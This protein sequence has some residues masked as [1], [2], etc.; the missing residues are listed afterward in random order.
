M[1][2]FGLL[3]SLKVFDQS[4]KHDA[5]LDNSNTVNAESSNSNNNTEI[6]D[7]KI[8]LS[9]PS[10][11]HDDDENIKNSPNPNSFDTPAENP[12]IQYPIDSM[13]TNYIK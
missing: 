1:G 3:P 12:E 7:D 10:E 4:V 9:D 13:L 11:T 5:A 8:S 2:L 6:S